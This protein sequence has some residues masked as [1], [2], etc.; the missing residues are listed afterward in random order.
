MIC[1]GDTLK[2]IKQI[3][4]PLQRTILFTSGIVL[5]MNLSVKRA[6]IGD[7]QRGDLRLPFPQTLFVNHYVHQKCVQE[8]WSVISQ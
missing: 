4:N 7:F 1:E 3:N 8:L 6:N 5:V 2:Q